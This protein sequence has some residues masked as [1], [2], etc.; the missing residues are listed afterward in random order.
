[1]GRK[2]LFPE[3]T[4]K[5][6]VRVT[7]TQKKAIKDLVGQEKY[8]DLSDFVRQAINSQLGLEWMKKEFGAAP[9]IPDVS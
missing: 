4:E 8:K 9:A 6:S 7:K 1:M 5:L 3:G 2:K